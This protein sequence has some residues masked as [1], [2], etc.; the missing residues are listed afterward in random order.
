[1][2][3]IPSTNF[4]SAQVIEEAAGSIRAFNSNDT[5]VRTLAGVLSGG[6]SSADWA[7]KSSGPSVIFVPNNISPE[8][9]SDLALYLYPTKQ[10]LFYDNTAEINYSGTWTSVAL[11]LNTNYQ[12]TI[13]NRVTGDITPINVSNTMSS[14]PAAY[15][16]NNG[17]SVTF[18]ANAS[19]LSKNIVILPRVDI[20]SRTLELEVTIGS[21]TGILS[22]FA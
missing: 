5:D 10:Y 22:I 16:L 2:A 18:T 21:S 17:E 9:G 3:T 15:I 11:A 6:Y 20:T 13:K 8:F 7:G 12:V 14:S 4:T 1:M 19:T